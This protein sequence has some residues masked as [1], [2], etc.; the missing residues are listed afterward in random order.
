[1]FLE[2]LIFWP[3]VAFLFVITHFT[4]LDIRLQVQTCLYSSYLTFLC[5]ISLFFEPSVLLSLGSWF[6]LGILKVDFL[7][8]FDP[9]SKIMLFVVTFISFLV[10]FYSVDYMRDDPEQGLFMAYLS[11][12]TF[13]MIVLVTSGNF[14]ILFF[15]WEGV[16]LASYLLINFWYTR[17]NAQKSA[18]KAVIVNKIGD[19]L[20]MYAFSA[21]FFAFQ[22]LDYFTVFVLAPHIEYSTLPIIDMCCLF[23][24]GG[25]AAKSA[26]LCL[27]TWLPDAMEGPT[28]VSALIHAATMVTA[29]IFL[30]VRCSPL[31]EFSE[32]T[33]LITTILG[34]LTAFFAATV[35][36]CQHDIKRI[37]A[38]STCSQL[39]YMMMAVGLSGYGFAM[40]HLFNHAFF[41]AALFLSAGSVIHSCANEQ[42]LRKMGGSTQLLP[43]TYVTVLWTSLSLMGI[44]FLSGFYSK[45][46]ILELAFASQIGHFSFILGTV[47]AFLTSLYSI[48]L[49]VLTFLVRINSFR[50]HIMNPHEPSFMTIP[51]IILFVFSI[52]SGF[53]GHDFFLNTF[54]SNNLFLFLLVIQQILSLY[55]FW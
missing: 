20:L 48:R 18:I 41:K 37:I 21:I 30:L 1:M 39:G 46:S 7:F 17:I 24:L 25:A 22:S 53:F 55:H 38:Y 26:Q 19:V 29:G 5:S 33:L 45:D 15:G 2:P 13:F 42:D 23:L 49:L 50:S 52:I 8:L 43:L 27:H 11:L 54:F 12:F 34:S 28:P 35:A 16:G 47:S 6:H 44:P 51:L 32:F 4:C 10:H 3:L 36:L 14:A 31:F 9:L 40:Y